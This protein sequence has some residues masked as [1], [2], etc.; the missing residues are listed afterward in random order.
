ML[1]A[2]GGS[3]TSIA[4]KAL[5][6]FAQVNKRF[7]VPEVAPE[8]LHDVYFDFTENH[9][10]KLRIHGW[11]SKSA[12]P[13]A[14]TLVYLHGNGENVQSMYEGGFFNVFAQMGF[15]VIAVD[16]PGLGHSIGTPNQHTLTQAG[17]SAVEWV[18][19]HLPRSRII[20]WGRSL[21]AAVAAQTAHRTRHMIHGLILTSPWN[22]FMDVAIAAMGAAKDLPEEWVEQHR[23]DSQALAADF[24]FPVL[25]H[26][27]VKDKVIPIQ[28]GRLFFGA[29]INSHGRLMR[30]F[31]ERE[32]NDIFKEEQL[33]RDVH[34]FRP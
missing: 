33:W 31:S 14:H 32:H 16:Y 1:T 21:G 3:L 6:P 15:N 18:K 13:T 12:G 29:L 22:R 7:P 20:V 2:C 11:Y 19:A 26:H 5:Y 4:E 8:G 27:G 28:F 24:R 10:L 17:V 30:E 34:S 9:E 23:Y 25:V